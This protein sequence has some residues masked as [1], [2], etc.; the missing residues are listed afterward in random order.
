M[1]AGGR[2]DRLGLGRNAF[3]PTLLAE[4]GIR[5]LEGLG[6][7]EVRGIEPGRDAGPP[8]PTLAEGMPIPGAAATPCERC[9]KAGIGG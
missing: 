9:S 6:A 1:A 4:G 5:E 2:G 3:A 8:P 7:V